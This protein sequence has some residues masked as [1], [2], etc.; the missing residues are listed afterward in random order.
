MTQYGPELIQNG[1]FAD[2][3]IW[4]K[5]GSVLI[6]G[7]FAGFTN[8]GQ[9]T[10]TVPLVAGR[11]YKTR[12]T[13][14]NH[15]SGTVDL[16]VGGTDGT[17]RT[18]D[19]T[20]TETIEAGSGTAEIAVQGFSSPDLLVDDVSVRLSAAENVFIGEYNPDGGT[21]AD[22]FAVIQRSSDTSTSIANTHYSNSG[23]FVLVI[24]RAIP[25]TPTDYTGAGS[26]AD[27]EQDF[28]N[29]LDG[30]IDDCQ[31][32]SGTAGY[33][34]TR[35]WTVTESARIDNEDRFVAKINVAWG[36]ATS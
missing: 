8:T 19:G 20:Y 33:L 24:E 17:N 27:A 9:V 2:D 36:L 4:S 1:D 5:N 13:V 12:F 3:S 16:D 28:Y 34:I 15:S 25:T 14:S 22:C 35:S 26:E 21:L 32:L 11:Q 30:V 29:F 7:G 31:T 18:A 6:S 23:E 10:Q